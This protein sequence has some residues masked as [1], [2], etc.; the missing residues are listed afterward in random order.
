VRD[1]PDAMDRAVVGNILVQFKRQT[2]IIHAFGHAF[3][4]RYRLQQ[5]VAHAIM[6]PHALAYLL[7]HVD[8]RRTLLAQ[9]LGIDATAYSEADL[10]DA[11]VGAVDEIRASL[12]LPARLRELDPVE[13]DDLTALAE[14]TIDDRAMQ[15]VPDGLNPTVG[16]L[17]RV[18]EAA[19]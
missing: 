4:R 15:R 8:T 19:W 1:D 17:E 10:A 14:Y 2:S 9:G 7:E 16:E 13:R 12:G 5:G 6:A 11:I 3:A 18:L